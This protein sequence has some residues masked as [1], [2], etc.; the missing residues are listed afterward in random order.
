MSTGDLSNVNANTINGGGTHGAVFQWD[1][2]V[3]EWVSSDTLEVS[4]VK[5]GTV[6][7]GDPYGEITGVENL[8]LD[9][10]DPADESTFV[11]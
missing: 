10:T 2:N 7:F 11:P 3:G 1:N 4:E 8:D 6:K 5:T 9:A